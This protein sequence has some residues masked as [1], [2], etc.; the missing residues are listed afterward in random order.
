MRRHTTH[1]VRGR[2]GRAIRSTHTTVVLGA[3]PR[4]T[5][6][7][8]TD[9]VTLHLV[10][11]HFGRMAMHELHEAAA[12][13]GRDLDVG[14]LA[15]ALE[16]GAKLVLG[17]VARQTTDEDSRVVGIGELI[18]GLHGVERRTLV[19]V[20]GGAAPHRTGSRMTGNGRHHLVGSARAAVAT[21]LMGAVAG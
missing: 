11:G 8:V 9:R 1:V 2:G 7:R 13:A 3:T 20:G 21:V 17:D 15:E 12:L 18:H 16:E 14:D 4:Q 10:D 6:P 5:N 19:V